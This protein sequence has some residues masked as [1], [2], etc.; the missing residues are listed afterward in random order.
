MV[1]IPLTD[2]WGLENSQQR[3]FNMQYEGRKEDD[4]SSI[5]QAD[6]SGLHDRH[7][8]A[9]IKAC[10]GGDSG[11]DANRDLLA[12]TGIIAEDGAT[13]GG[14]KTR[15]G[16][17]AQSE[18]KQFIKL[19]LDEFP[20][21]ADPIPQRERKARKARRTGQ[22]EERGERKYL[23]RIFLGR[24]A[25][26]KRRYHNKNF[27][28]TKKQAD[29]WLRDALVRVDKGEPIEA[30]PIT[31]NEYLDKWLTEAAKPRLRN[32]TFQGYSELLERYIRPTIGSQRL[33]DVTALDLQAVYTKMIEGGL[34]ART[35]RYLHA[36]I[37]SAFKQAMKWQILARDITRLV[38][39]PKQQ[40]QEM[41]ALSREEAALFLHHVA[42]DRYSVLFT[43]ALS[44]GMRP[45]EYTALKWSDIDWQRGTATVQRVLVWIKG[46]GWQYEEP[47]T[48]KSR[49]A[50]PLSPS[51]LAKL[52]SYQKSQLEDR[53]KAGS[54]WQNHD[55]IFTTEIG[56]PIYVN[57]LRKRHFKPALKRAGLPE[58]IRLYDLRH[59]MATLL[60]SS[61]EHPKIVS[62]RLGH[63]SITLTL[64]TYS[65]VLPD[66]QK[67]AVEKLENLLFSGVGTL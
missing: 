16:N 49:R 22:I 31:I 27:H 50:V 53:L 6:G 67:G 44:S 66:M 60:L 62:E 45:E 8:L 7:T 48:P 40:R 46:G 21:S 41:Y 52:K 15:S 35:V 65:H 39:L 26:G 34:S 25:N 9:E 42:D 13:E 43:F 30:A 58:K 3:Y 55:L 59:T 57:N 51:M 10:T 64:D 61:N 2:L 37:S 24:D 19:T 54:M 38:D 32:R 20:Q 11:R 28:G 18:E 63:S 5:R 47:K 33:A 29:A 12:D 56:S 4:S 17:E 36:V 23:I 1:N 14:Q